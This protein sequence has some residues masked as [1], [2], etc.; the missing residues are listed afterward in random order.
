MSVS[1]SIA[2]GA[3]RRAT[4]AGIGFTLLGIFLFVC[5]DALGKWLLGTYSVWQM[6]VIRSIAALVLLS[7]FLW[8]EG[9][10]AFLTAPRP[11]LQIIRFGLGAAESSLFFIAVVYLPL[12]D[13]MAFYLAAPIYVTALSALLLKENVGWRRWTSVIAGFIGVIITLNPSAATLT[14]PA[15][16][17]ILGSFCYALLMIAT[18][19]LRGTSDIVMASGQV[20]MT[21]L[22]ALPGA[23]LSWARPPLMEGLLLMLLGVVAVTALICINRSLKLAPASVVAPFQYTMIVW[24][25]LLGYLV[26]GDIPKLNVVIGSIIIVGAGLFIFWREQVRARESVVAPP[27]AE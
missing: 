24:G 4:L 20:A 23:A 9:R 2:G 1:Q 10:A 7:P 21:M 16:I 17:A 11:G 12:A 13:A 26:F 3:T 25:A 15:L 8:R 22:V 14:W 18:R 5:N 27:P 6:L 19:Y